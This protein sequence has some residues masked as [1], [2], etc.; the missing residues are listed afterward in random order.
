MDYRIF[1]M[2]Y[3]RKLQNFTASAPVPRTG[4]TDQCPSP[5]HRQAQSRCVQARLSQ[6]HPIST[7]VLWPSPLK[8][9]SASS[10]EYLQ[11]LHCLLAW[12]K[13][14]HGTPLWMQQRA[15]S[16]PCHPRRQCCFVF[17]SASQACC[18]VW[19]LCCWKPRSWLLCSES[20]LSSGV[21]DKN[22]TSCRTTT[23][24]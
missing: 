22:I 2:E 7:A 23:V 13:A 9:T 15:G 16:L 4:G 12:E 17:W 24:Y 21:R 20:F 11:Y 8:T 3:T 14:L 6:A 5:A 19:P 18:L 10:L 1:G